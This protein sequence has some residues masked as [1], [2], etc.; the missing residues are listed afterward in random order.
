[1]T[2]YF[3]LLIQGLHKTC[4]QPIDIAKWYNFTTFDISSDLTFGESFE[5]LSTGKM[6]V[7]VRTFDIAKICSVLTVVA[8]NLD[9]LWFHQIYVYIGVV[10]RFYL[11]DKMLWWLTP[12]SKKVLL[13]YFQ[14][15]KNEKVAKRLDWE[16]DRQDLYAILS[17]T[18]FPVTDNL[19]Y[20]T[21]SEAHEHT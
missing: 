12:E 1:M 3:D 21:R 8:V 2:K 18:P 9:N 7:S 6:H 11:L 15:L 17:M 13:A 10:A 14:R 4:D 20:D 5:C 19:K 16:T